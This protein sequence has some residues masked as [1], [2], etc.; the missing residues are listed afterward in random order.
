MTLRRMSA[1]VAVAAGLGACRAEPIDGP[2]IDEPDPS[3]S[4]QSLVS[5]PD[6]PVPNLTPIAW[7][8]LPPGT[9]PQGI[10]AVIRNLDQNTRSF[11]FPVGGGFD[12]VP[13]PARP[14]DRLEIEVRGVGAN[15]L[16]RAEFLVPAIRR[17]IVVRTNPTPRKRDVPLNS[18]MVIVFSEPVIGQT[19]TPTSVRLVGNAGAVSGRLTLDPDGLRAEFVPDQPLAPNNTYHLEVSDEVTD[20]SGDRLETADIEFTTAAA[21]DPQVGMSQIAFGTCIGNDDFSCLVQVINADGSNPR[22]LTD[23]PSPGNLDPSWSPDG[24][25]IAFASFRHCIFEPGG[26]CYSEIFVMN[27]DGSEVTKLTAR[28]DTSSFGPTWSPDGRRIAFQST[29]FTP[30]TFFPIQNVD[31]FVVN[32]DGTGLS[33]LTTTPEHELAP[34]WSPDGNRILFLEGEGARLFVMDA[35]GSNRVRLTDGPDDAGDWSPDGTRIAFGRRLSGS[36]DIFVM[37]ADG[38]GQ[39]PLTQG[40]SNDLGPAW[41]RDGSR[42]AFLSYVGTDFGLS[43]MNADGSRVTRIFT[44]FASSPTWSPGTL[45]PLPA[46]ARSRRP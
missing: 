31:V 17:P 4:T 36:F 38:S 25:Q 5:N 3:D 11:A 21:P 46:A 20:R 39:T 35:N 19:V 37:N 29:A 32:V 42:I 15:T 7:V 43:V 16:L 1:I 22:A 10:A 28:R 41:S 2:V 44:G 24:R 26:G 33:Q 13:V 8:H 23:P 14:Q 6:L 30:G 34:A 27:T 18:V 9:V 12:P 40:P 45:P